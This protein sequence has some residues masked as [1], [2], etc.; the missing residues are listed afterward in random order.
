MKFRTIIKHFIPLIFYILIEAP[1]A[2][3]QSSN[4]ILIVNTNQAKLTESEKTDSKV[5]KILNKGDKLDLIQVTFPNGIGSASRYKVRYQEMEGYITSYFIESSSILKEM[6]SS[7]IKRISEK[8]KT[9]QD[10]IFEVRKKENQSYLEKLKIDEAA[11]IRKNDSIAEIMLKNAKAQGISK[12]VVSKERLDKFVKKYGPSNGKK[13]AEGLIWIG[14]KEEMLIDSWGYPEDINTT[15]T[16][17]GSRK[18]YVYGSGQYVYVVNGLVD[19][20]QN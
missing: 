3:G 8:Q 20:W 7:E 1:V 19:A 18:Q 12:S 15:V 16:R 5:L 11:E 2:F 4:V 6:E 10:S 14:M 17:Y 13:I 9:L